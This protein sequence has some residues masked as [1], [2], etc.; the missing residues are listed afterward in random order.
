M[1]RPLSLRPFRI[2]DRDDLTDDYLTNVVGF[3]R[4]EA[5]R[6]ATFDDAGERARL[7]AAA[8]YLDEAV[9]RIEAT[10]LM[11]ALLGEAARRGL[12]L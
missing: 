5:T 10:P 3:V 8:E 2:T 9:R 11:Q 12:T 4:A 6:W 7:I 1:T